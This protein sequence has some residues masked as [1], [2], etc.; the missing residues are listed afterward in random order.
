MELIYLTPLNKWNPYNL[1][2]KGA[3]KSEE[4]KTVNANGRNGG[5]TEDKAFDGVN[6]KTYYLTP[7]ELY[8]GTETHV[9]AADTTKGSVGVLDPEKN[10]RKVR[11][12][13]IRIFLP[14]IPGVGILRQRYPIMPVHAEGSATW[15]ELEA[16][17]D[18]LMESKTHA[19]LFREKLTPDD[20][21]GGTMPPEKNTDTTLKTGKSRLKGIIIHEHEVT[22]TE[23]EVRSLKSGKRVTK[24]TSQVQGHEHEITIVWN[25]RRDI[26]IMAR[27]AST[28]DITKMFQRKCKDQHDARMEVVPDQ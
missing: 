13:G 9:D 18:F 28:P 25:K 26:Y 6:S 24:T 1:K 16:V 10:V 12:S 2:D 22:L 3:F 8:T 27:C 21:N 15:K 17:Q 20:S 7:N 4:G 19:R 23:D 14:K 5:L 11:A